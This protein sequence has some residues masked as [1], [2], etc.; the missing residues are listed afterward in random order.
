MFTFIWNHPLNKNNKVKSIAKFLS[1]QFLSYITQCTIVLPW[2][3]EA[4][5]S[6]N[7][8]DSGLSGNLYVGL[9]EYKDMLFLMHLLRDNFL[10]VD[11][12]ANM[13]AYTVLASKVC[14]SKTIAFEPIKQSFKRLLDQIRINNIEQNV[15]AKEIGLG[16]HNGTLFFTNNLNAMNKVAFVNK[17]NNVVEVQ[18]SRLDDEILNSTSCV[19]K[20]DVEG[21]EYNVVKGCQQL[22]R[23]KNVLAMIIELNSSSI[24]FGHS[25]FEIHELIIQNNYT[26]IEYNPIDR[27]ITPLTSFNQNKGN[28]IYVRDVDE[29]KQLVRNGKQFNIKTGINLII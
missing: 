1:W 28:T 21:Y 11:V 7:K 22:L 2:I 10:F 17:S 12:G 4:K 27:E 23:S 6:L 26:P 19:I 3:D 15:T 16:N 5:L 24:E 13:G 29:V 14:N 9:M 20:I 18:I 25:N 8:G